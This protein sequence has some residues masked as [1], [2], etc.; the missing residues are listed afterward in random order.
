MED[1]AASEFTHSREVHASCRRS[2]RNRARLTLHSLT[3]CPLSRI[4]YAREKDVQ[5]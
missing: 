4:N 1:Y 2:S 5:I 3:Q